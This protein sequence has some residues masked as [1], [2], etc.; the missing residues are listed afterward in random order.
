[1]KQTSS[2]STSANSSEPL[3]QKKVESDN[4][5]I[6]LMTSKLEEEVVEKHYPPPSLKP[7]HKDHSPKPKNNNVVM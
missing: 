7:S 4:L 1:M 2:A 5:N 6:I 3:P